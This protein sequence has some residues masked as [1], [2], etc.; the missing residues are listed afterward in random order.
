ME[1][2]PKAEEVSRCHSVT[3]QPFC[4]TLSVRP[5]RRAEDHGK[6]RAMK[7]TSQHFLP[8]LWP[9]TRDNAKQSGV[10]NNKMVRQTREEG[11]LGELGRPSTDGDSR[12]RETPD[13]AEKQR[14]SGRSG[15]RCGVK[16]HAFDG[17]YRRLHQW[18]YQNLSFCVVVVEFCRCVCFCVFLEE[19]RV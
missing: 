5:R 15:R 19:R 9:R 12:S 16:R 7:Q 11:T 3:G 14:V 6:R 13:Q 10:R 17:R 8:S 18:C 2:V 1:N 4:N